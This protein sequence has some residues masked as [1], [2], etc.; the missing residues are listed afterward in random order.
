MIGNKTSH[1]PTFSNWCTYAGTREQEQDR[2]GRRKER[3]K[4]RKDSE[5]KKSDKKSLMFMKNMTQFSF[6]NACSVAHSRT[7]Q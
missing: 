5:L 4:Q 2:D 7:V 1:K 3:E 6:H